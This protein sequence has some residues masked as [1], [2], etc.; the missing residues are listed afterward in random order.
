MEFII[1]LGWYDSHTNIQPETCSSV[2]INE[3]NQ[4]TIEAVGLYPDCQKP[5]LCLALAGRC[6]LFLS[7]VEMNRQVVASAEVLGSLH[8][9]A[10]LPTWHGL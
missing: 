3:K 2:R 7:Q 9:E 8:V 6:G 10:H 5:A 4:T 1:S